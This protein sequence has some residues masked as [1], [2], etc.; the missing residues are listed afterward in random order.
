[1]SESIDLSQLQQAVQSAAAIR[2]RCK[3]Q[4]AGGAGDKV[5]PPTYANAVYAWEK[6]RVEGFESP[7]D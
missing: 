4:P 7:V 6:R 5:F 3:L 2:S 1:M